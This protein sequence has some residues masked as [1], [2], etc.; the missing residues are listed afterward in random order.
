MASFASPDELS[1]YTAGL[2]AAND[3]RAQVILD[4]ATQAIK[5]YCGW[6]IAPPET[7]TLYLDGGSSVIYLPTLKLNSVESI[8]VDGTVLAAT[9]YEWS[10]VTGNIRS[11][12]Y[13]GFPD[14]WGGTVVVFNS[15]FATT[16][17]D[18]KQV[19]LQVSALALSSPTGA[20]REQAG[21]VSMQ[22]AT[23]AP[24]VAGGLSLLERDLAVIDQY[25]IAKEV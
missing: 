20:T 17:A 5:N 11:K 24:G 7:I 23:T 12:L 14:S 3:P 18:L 9:D 1:A 8:T 15:G 6:N 19:V 21:Q 25:R 2:I 16:P 10:R 4:G 13:A 22:W